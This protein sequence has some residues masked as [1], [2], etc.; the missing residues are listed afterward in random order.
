[1][2]L[3]ENFNVDIL[4]EK[5][6]LITFNLKEKLLA[7]I[8]KRPDNLNPQL[9]ELEFVAENEQYKAKIISQHAYVKKAGNEYYL[10][11]IQGYL[12]FKYKE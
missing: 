2:K 6:T 4:N 11:N 12:L 10:Q 1:M 8:K 3:N 9:D 5:D 7:E